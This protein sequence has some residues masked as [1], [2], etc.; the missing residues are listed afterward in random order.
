MDQSTAAELAHLLIDVRDNLEWQNQLLARQAPADM[1]PPPS[2]YEDRIGKLD[3][4]N[5]KKNLP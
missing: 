5:R 3:K 4:G 2:R 1:P